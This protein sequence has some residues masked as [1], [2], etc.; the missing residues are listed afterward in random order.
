M[1]ATPSRSAIH[2]DEPYGDYGFRSSYDARGV[3]TSTYT[4][5]F[6]FYHYAT[7]RSLAMHPHDETSKK[8]GHCAASIPH[9]LANPTTSIRARRNVKYYT[10]NYTFTFPS[11]F[12]FFL[13]ESLA[14]VFLF[15]A[16]ISQ[17]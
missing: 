9:I 3:I 4:Y 16:A 1:Y 10:N 14:V 15:P 8:R 5:T 11:F 7:L 12:S 17:C 6:I 13:A 2:A